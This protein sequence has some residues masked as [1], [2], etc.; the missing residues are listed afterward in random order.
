MIVADPPWGP[1]DR[2][3]PLGVLR[4]YTTMPVAEISAYLPEL[5]VP[6]LPDAV[7]FLWRIACMPREAL[8]VCD[9]WGFEPKA[10]IVWLKETTQGRPQIGMGSYV[11]AAHEVCLIAT[12]GRPARF[13]RDRTVPSYFRAS[14][15]E[16][17]RKP[18]EFFAI[19]ERLFPG[20][21][22]ELFS[23]T[24]RSGWVQVGKECGKWRA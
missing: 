12:R 24:Q 17:S 8:E 11:R 4:H 19:V 1:R 22:L 21:R 7:L 20:P 23:R 5:G 14:R 9:A 2:H 13:R 16:H 3:G 10:E 18:D 6:V 15:R